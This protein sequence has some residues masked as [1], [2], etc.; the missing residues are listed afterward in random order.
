MAGIQRETK[1]FDVCICNKLRKA[2]GG[3]C[4]SKMSGL[5]TEGFLAASRI[6][7]RANGFPLTVRLKFCENHRRRTRNVR[8]DC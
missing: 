1:D 8:S 5:E 6:N 4:S 3:L 2:V 7:L